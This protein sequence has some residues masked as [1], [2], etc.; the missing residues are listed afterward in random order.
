RL[1]EADAQLVPVGP[2]A[3]DQLTPELEA[4]HWNHNSVGALVAS[5]ANPTGT[6]LRRDELAPVTHALKARN[7]HM[8]VDEIYHGLT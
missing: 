5:P 2:P 7:G 4:T 1:I 3:R 6:L 8:V